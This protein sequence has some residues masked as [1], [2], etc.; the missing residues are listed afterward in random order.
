MFE[1]T[2]WYA[3]AVSAE[4]DYWIGY[5][6]RL[7]TG[8]LSVNYS[9]VLD[10]SGQRHSL[11]ASEIVVREGEALW[12]APALGVHARWRGSGRAIRK[13]IY[14]DK[15]GV[16]DWECLLPAAAA[17]AGRVVGL[18][19]VERLRLT[20][21]P[22]RLPVR[23]LRWGR[24]VSERNWVV[25]IDWQGDFNSRT[26]FWNGRAVDAEDIDDDG[27][28]F[29]GGARLG[30]D[31]GLVIRTGPLGSTVLRAVPGLDRI[32]PAR[33]FRVEECKWRSA[34]TLE[35]AGE[36]PDKGW[37]IHEVVRWP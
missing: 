36:P 20:I 13:V 2:K 12:R 15:E 4:G 26:V 22:W 11:R 5:C 28:A 27:V 31:R 6:A 30:F 1:L 23:S 33:I 34:A 9:S 29:E 37:A 3:D 32:A 14:H 10:S 17:S 8:G 24:F 7:N 25:W 19:Y 35:C 21:A 16:V 18:G